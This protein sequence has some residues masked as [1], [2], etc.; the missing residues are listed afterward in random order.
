MLL[1]SG[2]IVARTRGCTA[3]LLRFLP[4]MVFMKVTFLI[5]ES[6]V[7]DCERTKRELRNPE[8]Q[9]YGA[10][11]FFEVLI[12]ASLISAGMFRDLSFAIREYY[13]AKHFTFRICF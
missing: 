2:S 4:L 7:K 6:V 5:P 11:I 9:M 8:G 13:R 12:H 10:R 3:A 1:S